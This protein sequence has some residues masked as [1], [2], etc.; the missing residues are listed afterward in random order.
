MDSVMLFL[1]LNLY[2]KLNKTK[3]TLI[4]KLVMLPDPDWLWSTLEKE[5]PI[6]MY[7]QMLLLMPPCLVLSE[8]KEKCGIKMIN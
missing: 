1:K 7:L 3:L 5:S 4:S 6:S 8:M 2:L